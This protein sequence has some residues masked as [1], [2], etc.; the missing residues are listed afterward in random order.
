ML[1]YCMG[2]FSSTISPAPVEPKPEPKPNPKSK[3]NYR[4]F[5]DWSDKKKDR[6]YIWID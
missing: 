2:N 3:K 5:N 4:E 1:G 6:Q